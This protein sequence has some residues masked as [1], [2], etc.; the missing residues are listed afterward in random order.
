MCNATNRGTVFT[1][2]REVLNSLKMEYNTEF[3]VVLFTNIGKIVCDVAP[4]AKR[5]SLIAFTDNPAFFHIDISAL[6]NETEAFDEQLINV[7]NAVIYK[8]TSNEESIRVDQM[9]LFA[10]Q[11]TGFTLERKT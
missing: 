7:K 6:F 9:I 1:Q 2:M 10:D 4:P 5:D 11:I 8:N 3:Q